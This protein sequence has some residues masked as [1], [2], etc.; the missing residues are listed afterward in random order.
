MAEKSC[1]D[2]TP[3]STVLSV[4][5]FLTSRGLTHNNGKTKYLPE[6]MTV[7]E[8]KAINTTFI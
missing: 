2:L 5:S 1:E 8:W 3:P 6:C 4:A 7:K